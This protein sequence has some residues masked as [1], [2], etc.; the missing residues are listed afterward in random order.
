MLLLA[1]AHSAGPLIAARILQEAA[2]GAATS[3]AGATLLDLEDH[4]HPGRSA[5][6]NSI[7]LLAGMAAGVLLST[8]LVRFAPAPTSTVYVLLGGT[9]RRPRRAQA[10]PGPIRLDQLRFAEADL[11]LHQL[12][13]EGTRGF[14]HGGNRFSGLL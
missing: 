6:T 7:D 8:L 13:S 5:L 3:A 10:V 14:R 1:S 11:G 2:T 4:R 9:P 12:S